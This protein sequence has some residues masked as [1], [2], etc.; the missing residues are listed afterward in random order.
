MT[1]FGRYDKNFK[2]F[3]VTIALHITEQMLFLYHIDKMNVR[4]SEHIDGTILIVRIERQKQTPSQNGQL[5]VDF[6]S[7][8]LYFY[9]NL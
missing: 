8:Y 3:V 5:L 4:Y 7:L 6:D 2:F 9:I 1:S